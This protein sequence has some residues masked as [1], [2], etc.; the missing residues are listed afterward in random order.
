LIVAAHE[1]K[2]H[3]LLLLPL[4]LLALHG[5]TPCV[6][7]LE[8][9]FAI[10]RHGARNLL[11]KSANL[12]EL[13]TNGGPTLL[14]EGVRMCFNAGGAIGRWRATRMGAAP[15]VKLPH[16]AQGSSSTRAT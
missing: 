16:R 1:M 5:T 9:V 14:P 7:K 4:L 12:S 8:L 6:A 13:D 3:L 2:R 11:P 15:R 10:T